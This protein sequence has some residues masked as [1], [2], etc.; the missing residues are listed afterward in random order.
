MKRERKSKLCKRVV[1]NGERETETDR[2]IEEGGGGGKGEGGKGS[3][4]RAV[5]ESQVAKR[6]S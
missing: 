5:V 2:E 4:T 6:T 3:F 1:G